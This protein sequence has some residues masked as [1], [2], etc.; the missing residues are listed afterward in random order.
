MVRSRGDLQAMFPG[1]R[2]EG[3][4][5]SQWLDCKNQLVL[6]DSICR[7]SRSGG[8]ASMIGSEVCEAGE[9]AGRRGLPARSSGMKP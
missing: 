9:L 8:G 7:P 1:L 4:F 3:E 5:P 2:I 6:G